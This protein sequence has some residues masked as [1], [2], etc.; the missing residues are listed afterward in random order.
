[1]FRPTHIETTLRMVCHQKKTHLNL[2]KNKKK[3]ENNEFTGRFEDYSDCYHVKLLDLPKNKVI[4]YK[5]TF[6]S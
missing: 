3:R 1:M 6:Y 2:N 4:K 5:L